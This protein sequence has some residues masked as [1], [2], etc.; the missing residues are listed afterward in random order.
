VKSRWT[1][2]AVSAGQVVK[3][4]RRQE[5]GEEG[6]GTGGARRGG[7]PLCEGALAPW[8]QPHRT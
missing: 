4:K 8:L 7:G 2:L 3:G 6:E 5:E 1:E